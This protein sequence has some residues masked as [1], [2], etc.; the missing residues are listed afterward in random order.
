VGST[1][2]SGTFPSAD[3]DARTNLRTLTNLVTRSASGYNGELGIGE[4]AR[5]V[6]GE[7]VKWGMRIYAATGIRIAYSAWFVQYDT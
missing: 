7:H 4:V 1:H 3:C 2:G 6:A 5:K